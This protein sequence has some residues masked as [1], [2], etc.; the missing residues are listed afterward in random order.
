MERKNCLICNQKKI[1]D[2]INLGMH[3]FADTFINRERIYESEDIYPLIVQLCSN[4]GNIQTKIE[5]PTN[6]RYNKF[7]Y[8]Y[9]SSNSDFAKNHWKSFYGDIH[10]KT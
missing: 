2:I 8:S 6:E 10:K 3:P 1:N 5:T 7:D 4:C 9:T